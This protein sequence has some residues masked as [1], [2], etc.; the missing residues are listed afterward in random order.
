MRVKFFRLK[1]F[2]HHENQENNYIFIR[3]EINTFT[4]IAISD[5]TMIEQ[6]INNTPLHQQNQKLIQKHLEIIVT[7]S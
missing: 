3:H 7:I 2:D 1:V 4:V 5:V 6:N